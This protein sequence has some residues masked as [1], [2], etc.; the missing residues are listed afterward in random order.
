MLT[1]RLS[2]SGGVTANGLRY[3]SNDNLVQLPAYAR[4]DAAISYRAGRLELAVNARNLFDSRYYEN[5]GSNFQIFPGTPRDILLTV[6][7]SR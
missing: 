6:R 5:A 7:V 3:T 1:S 4:T 2:V